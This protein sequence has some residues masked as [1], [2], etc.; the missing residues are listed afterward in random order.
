M[1]AKRLQ[2]RV[3]IEA[4]QDQNVSSGEINLTRAQR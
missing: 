4:V 1:L 3:L 2:R